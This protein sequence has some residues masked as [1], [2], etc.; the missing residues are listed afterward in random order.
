MNGKPQTAI[1][2]GEFYFLKRKKHFS[3]L[4]SPASHLLSLPYFHTMKLTGIILISIF[5]LSSS[6]N[7]SD[8][9]KGDADNGGL[10]LPEKVEAVV[11]SDRTGR[12]RHIAVN[13]N[14]DI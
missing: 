4:P 5:I 2:N 1:G 11:V 10:F 8:L 9:P 3:C 14:G 7:Q 12:A 6:C 13:S